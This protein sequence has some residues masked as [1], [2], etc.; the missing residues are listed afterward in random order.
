MSSYEQIL[1]KYGLTEADL[2]S[3]GH[4]GER[5][6]LHSLADKMQK[7]E[8]TISEIK[9]HVF[10][11]KYRVELDLVNEPEFIASK[12]LPFIKVRND[13]NIYLKARLN[14]YLLLEAFLEG[15]GKAKMAVERAISNI[16]K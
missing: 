7:R 2:D 4:M 14:N 8:M 15:P 10:S 16:K 13:K 6:T 9:D 1:Q 12:I 5:E 3:P 11:M